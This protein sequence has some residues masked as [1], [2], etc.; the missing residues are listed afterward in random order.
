M[1]RIYH[2]CRIDHNGCPSCGGKDFGQ[3]PILTDSLAAAWELTDSERREF[4]EREGHTCLICGMSKRVRM[5]YCILKR[6]LPDFKQLD[7]LHINRINGLSQPLE[8]AR[9]L[10]ETVH[11]PDLPFGAL[12]EGY[13]NQ[14]MTNLKFA[15]RSFDVVIHSET[16]EHVHDYEK[17]LSEATRVLRSGGRQFYTVPLLHSRLTR[18]RM[19]VGTNNERIDLLPLSFHGN[20]GEFP[21]VWEFGGDF[22]QKRNARIAQVHYD[23]HWSNPTIFTIVEG[24]S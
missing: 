1:A 5:L 24:K 8:A 10:V 11:R 20:E 7:I 16:L 17:A 9:T 21:V 23:D 15:D 19:I 6:L 22:L 2:Y 12:V 18:R 14:D 13:V 4:D 3:S